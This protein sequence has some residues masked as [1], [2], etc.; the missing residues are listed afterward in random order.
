MMLPVALNGLV[1]HENQWIA[2]TVTFSSEARYEPI[3]T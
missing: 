1:A 3:F 2:I